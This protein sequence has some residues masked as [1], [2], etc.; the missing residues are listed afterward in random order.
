MSSERPEG[1]PIMNNEPP[2]FANDLRDSIVSLVIVALVWFLFFG[3][4]YPILL[5][6]LDIIGL[7]L[8]FFSIMIILSY[9]FAIFSRF[10]EI[11]AYKR[12]SMNTNLPYMN[13][14][15]KCP[16][17]ERNRFK[18]SCKAEKIAPF[19]VEIFEKCHK[20]P[21][22]E[23]CWP[24]RIPSVLEVINNTQQYLPDYLQGMGLFER[25][26]YRRLSE[27]Q[28]SAKYKQ[29][30]MFILAEM[31]EKA[32]PAS[33]LMYSTLLDEF[34]DIEV[35][36]SAGYVL[37]QIKD[38]NGIKP[39]IELVG[40][41]EDQRID[42][43]IRGVITRYGEMAIP[44]LIEEVQD[45]GEDTRCGNLVEIMGKIGHDN[46]V[47]TLENLL[48]QDSTGEYT[49]LKI[50]Y[51]LEDIESDLSFKVL[52]AYLEKAPEEEVLIIKQT[53][54]KNKLMSFPI[55]IG[56][57]ASEEISD[58]YYALIGDILAEVD[59]RT[60]D[61]LFT[62]L[63]ETN[64]QETVIRLAQILKNNTPEEEEYANLNQILTKHIEFT[65]EIG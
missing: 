27:E 29:Q 60:Y 55:L 17:L 36:V 26:A 43:T 25:F 23:V 24:E 11:I 13:Y 41:V 7:F 57:L 65:Q 6:F 61:R 58:D 15:T 40:E 12:A 9:T 1:L 63:R 16:F 10:V 34:Q 48:N 14:K 54:L 62:K 44:Y 8:A 47:P 50:F 42:Q 46:S 5:A 31:K 64:D 20:E 30:L 4:V 3:Y 51:A 59:A 52:V 53:C 35:R 39:L 22:W 37:A 38:E 2:I 28:L 33:Q 18:F 56:L 19:E 45:C 21:M 32:A 49:R